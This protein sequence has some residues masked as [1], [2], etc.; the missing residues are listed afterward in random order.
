[1]IPYGRQIIDIDDI[2]AVVEVLKSDWLTTGPKI[3]EFEDAIASFVNSKYAIAVSN[4]TAALHCAMFA[5]GI[6]KGDEVIVPP[7]T[8]AASANAI[9]Y[10]G[11]KPVFVDIEEDTLL[12]DPNK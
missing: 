3:D 5:A 9:L 10:I 1:M 6:T 8:F 12:I 11:A 7:M 2:N 4:G